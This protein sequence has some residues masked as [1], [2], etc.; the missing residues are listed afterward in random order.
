MSVT[1]CYTLFNTDI[2]MTSKFK[3]QPSIKKKH[4]DLYHIFNHPFQ[5]NHWI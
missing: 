3:S 1:L 5:K 4:L 2:H